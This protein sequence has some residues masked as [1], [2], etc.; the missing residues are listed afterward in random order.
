MARKKGSGQIV[1]N[2]FPY[3]DT[4]KRYYTFSYYV[5]QKYK[6]KAAKIPLNAAFTCPNRDGSKSIGGCTFCSAKGSGDSIL[7]FDD[8][9]QKQYLENLERAR[10]KWPECLGIA[11]FQSFSN[12]YADLDTLQKIYTP[13]FEEPDVC[14]IAIAT[15]PDC[16]DEEKAKWFGKIAKETDKECWIEFGLQTVHDQTAA[17]LNRA[18]SAREVKEALDLCRKYGLKTCVHLINGLPGESDEMMIESAGTLSLWHPDAVKI[19]MLHIIEGSVLAAKYK[20]FPFPLL[21]LEEYT[22]IVCRQLQVLEEDIIIERVTG[23][24]IASDLI[25]PEWTKNKTAVSNRIDQKMFE[26]GWVQGM[27][28]QR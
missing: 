27:L 16:F 20:L 12:T 25:A 17:A 24:G 9:L 15:R 22:D 8:S 13:F 11:Y 19:H 26:S 5:K 10:R 4:N 18:H 21:S 3:S 7:A 28:C 14:A 1:Q 6:K 2:P 23:D